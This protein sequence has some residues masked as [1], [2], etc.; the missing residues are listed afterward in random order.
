MQVSISS[1]SCRCITGCSS[2]M[3][4]SVAWIASW[5]GSSLALLIQ[6][7]CIIVG[8]FKPRRRGSLRPREALLDSTVARIPTLMPSSYTPR[9]FPPPPL[10]GVPTQFIIHQ[11]RSLA[12]S[13]WNRPETSDCTI[14]TLYVRVTLMATD[15][16]STHEVFPLELPTTPSSHEADVGNLSETLGNMTLDSDSARTPRASPTPERQ[17]MNSTG[18]E[19][20]PWRALRDHV[21][22][23]VCRNRLLPQVELKVFLG[24]RRL[25]LFAFAATA[26]VVDRPVAGHAQPRGTAP[27]SCSFRSRAV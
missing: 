11:L 7:P 26:T 4:P 1:P 15:A 5:A 19:L 12:P 25:S 22:M 23:Q 17:R 14:G 24:P 16:L 27:P 13:Y 6:R 20:P 9:P 21:A 10:V 18:T 8:I 3:F 2:G